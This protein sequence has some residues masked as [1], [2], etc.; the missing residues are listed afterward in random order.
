MAASSTETF[1][2]EAMDML[3]LAPKFQKLLMNPLREVKVEL[4]LERDSGELE[5]YSGYRVQHD[6]SRGPMKGGLRFHP[7]VDSSMMKS[8]ASLMTWKCALVDVPFGG[9]MGGIACDPKALSKN[10]LERLTRTYVVRI[11]ELIGPLK[12]IPAPDVNT[13]E[14]VM[15]WVMDQYS[16]IHGYTPP[17]VTGKPLALQGSQGR[18]EAAGLAACMVA[19]EYLATLGRKI[20][21]S[22]FVVQGF[23]NVGSHS[24]MCFHE[25]GGKVIAVTDSSGGVYRGRGL[26]IPRLVKHKQ[27]KGT[28]AGFKE[29]DYMSNDEALAQK[30][31]IFAAA[32]LDGMITGDVAA[33]M[34][35]KAVLESANAAV[36]PE[37]DAVLAR[38]GVPVIPDLIASSGGV[39]VSYYEWVQNLQQL[40]WSMEQV[41]EGLTAKIRSAWAKVWNGSKDRK[42]AMRKAAYIEAINKVVEALELR[43]L[44]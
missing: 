37:A 9:A 19:E 13:D 1:L 15:A 39:I 31:D 10:E 38:N 25:H 6:T 26:D 44:I 11:A 30:C 40:S 7:L 24:A 16:K 8:L 22:T 18:K 29:G 5:I 42:I 17:V 43:G 34:E 35:A 32:A 33:E 21:E 12:D 28:V 3:C 20:E 14:K 4:P 2:K 23:G 41:K 27:E 36:T